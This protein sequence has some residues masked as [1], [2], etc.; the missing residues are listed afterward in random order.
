MIN[1]KSAPTNDEEDYADYYIDVYSTISDSSILTAI[2]YWFSL[3]FR[4][5]LIDNG[6]VYTLGTNVYYAPVFPGLLIFTSGYL[7]IF[8][9]HG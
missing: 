1:M 2:T 6:T 8:H 3:L 9:L 5:P 7:N 4:N